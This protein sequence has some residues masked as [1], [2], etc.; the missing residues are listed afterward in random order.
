VTEVEG[1]LTGDAAKVPSGSPTCVTSAFRLPDYRVGVVR[2]DGGGERI[3]AHGLSTV[4]GPVWSPDGSRLAFVRCS[5]KC[6][7]FSISVAGTG[8]RR[9]TYTPGIDGLPSWSR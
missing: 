7:I 5:D 6:D 2:P 3:L 4:R 1:A 8:W 9:V